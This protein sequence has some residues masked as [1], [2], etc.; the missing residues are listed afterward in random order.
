MTKLLELT[1]SHGKILINVD[2]I[3]ALRKAHNDT[4]EMSIDGTWF[5][6]QESY[7]LIVKKLDRMEDVYCLRN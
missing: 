5:G 6:V 7:E 3:S 1:Q 2:K 4:T